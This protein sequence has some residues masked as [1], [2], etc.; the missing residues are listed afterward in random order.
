MRNVD[1][2][3]RMAVFFRDIEDFD[4]FQPKLKAKFMDGNDE[5]TEELLSDTKTIIRN[6]LPSDNIFTYKVGEECSLFQGIHTL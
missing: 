2:P 6:A 3:Q 1:R 4:Q 5:M